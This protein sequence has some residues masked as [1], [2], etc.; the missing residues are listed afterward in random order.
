MGQRKA[1]RAEVLAFNFLHIFIDFCFLIWLHWVLAVAC[2]IQ[3][4]DRGLT[5]SPCLGCAESQPLDRRGST[6][7]YL[8]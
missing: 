7:W 3:F 2:G 4:P 5:W 6:C 8:L 1:F